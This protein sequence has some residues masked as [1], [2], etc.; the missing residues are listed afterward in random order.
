[1]QQALRRPLRLTQKSPVD[2]YYLVY[3]DTMESA[4]V[5]LIM[6][7]MAAAEKVNGNSLEASLMASQANGDDV[8][9][10]LGKVLQGTAQVKDLR[11]LFHEKERE[12]NSKRV[13]EQERNYETGKKHL[14]EIESESTTNTKLVP[15]AV[16]PLDSF[17][18]AATYQTTLF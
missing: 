8:L 2:A 4:A 6:E 3:R 1:M 15:L 13:H 9:S 5:A 17:E 18:R 12:A 14:T 16:N 10:Q 11:A 7:K